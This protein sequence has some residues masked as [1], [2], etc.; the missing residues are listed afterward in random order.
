MVCAT[1]WGERPAEARTRETS[2]RWEAS[3]MSGVSRDAETS[4]RRRRGVAIPKSAPTQTETRNPKPKTRKSKTIVPTIRRSDDPTIRVMNEH[5]P[6]I[7][8]LTTILTTIHNHPQPS[9]TIL[10]HYSQ[11]SSTIISSISSPRFVVKLVCSFCSFLRSPSP[12]AC[13]WRWLH[14]KTRL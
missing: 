2:I 10:N 14:C 11:P 5:S 7:T 9:T 13:G 6:S 4:P 12:C 1:S 8:I 3:I